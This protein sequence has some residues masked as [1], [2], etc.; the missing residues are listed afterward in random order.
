MSFV[1]TPFGQT[2]DGKAVQKIT[3]TNSHGHRVSVMNWGALLLEV[4][5]PDRL[6]NLANVNMVFD[7]LDR[8]LE[9]HPGFGSSIGRFCNRIGLAKFD[10]DGETYQVTVN[11]G[12]HCLH[13]GKEN[14]SHKWWDA[15]LFTGKDDQ[16]RDEIG[17]RFS[18]LSPDGDEGFPGE[19]TAGAEYRWNDDNELT[20]IYSATTTKPTHVNLT[21]HAYWNLA[22]IAPGDGG[23]SSVH[24]HV[25][26][27]HCNETLDVDEDLIPTGSTSGVEGTP[28]DFLHPEM[29]GK[30][31]DQLPATKGYDHCYVVAGEPGKL[32]PA[33]SVLEPNSGRTL[34]IETTQPGMQL[35]TGNH[36]GG[37]DSSAGHKSHEAFCLETQ[38]YPDACNHPNFK[39]TL[40][41]PGDTLKETTIHRFGVDKD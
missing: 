40:L 31:I 28:F 35:Y 8:Y 27:L 21:N 7:S 22:G 38:H 15:D 26:L 23:A 34:E 16:G 39:S 37:N 1:T 11:H 17:V 25:L 20:V 4:E 3:M 30:R 9:P 13:G 41:R 10:I 36:L 32:R 5:V 14:F 12:K 29:I 19:V 24:D 18:L 2:K 33:A 6:G